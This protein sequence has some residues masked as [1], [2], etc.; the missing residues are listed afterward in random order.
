METYDV[1]LANTAVAD[2]DEIYAYV[3]SV[4]QEPATALRL[5]ETLEEVK[6]IQIEGR[7]KRVAAQQELRRIEAELQKELT[8][9]VNK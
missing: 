1:K 7:E 4:L 3:A 2:L 6:R 5:I 8:D 9:V